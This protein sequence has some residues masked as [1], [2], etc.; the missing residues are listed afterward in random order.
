MFE[1]VLLRCVGWNVPG[2]QLRAAQLQMAGHTLHAL[3]G[4]VKG[5][6]ALQLH[7]AIAIAGKVDARA[8]GG[9]V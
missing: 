7:T 1:W 2:H 5:I 3:A 8:G 6:R 9:F 4:D